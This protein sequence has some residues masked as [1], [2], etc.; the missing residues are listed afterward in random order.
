MSTPNAKDPFRSICLQLLDEY[1]KVSLDSLVLFLMLKN[2]G[3]SAL[4]EKMAFSR[5]DPVIAAEVRS[6]FDPLRKLLQSATDYKEIL[7]A[8]KN[9]QI[10]PWL[11]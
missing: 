10:K 11:M 2:R 9:T 8:L 1:E 4:Q 6:R 5:S 7:E 3:V